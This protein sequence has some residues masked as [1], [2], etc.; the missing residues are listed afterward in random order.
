MRLPRPSALLRPRWPI[1]LLALSIGLT[2][3]GVLEVLRATRSQARVARRVQQDYSRFASWSYRQHLGDAMDDALGDVL[4][5][6]NHG[7]NLH[8]SPR[9]PHARE[10]AHYL[11]YDP[12]CACHRADG[13][14]PAIFFGFTLGSDT[15]GLGINTHA[16]PAEGWEIDRPLPVGA[17]ARLTG[18][19]PDEARWLVDTLT[20][21]VRRGRGNGAFTFVV[22][23]RGDSARFLAYTLMP[24][25]WGD[26]VVYGA[27]YARDALVQGL[28]QVLYERPLLPAALTH[29]RA[30]GD[31]LQVQVSDARGRPLFEPR[32]LE[33]WD[34]DLAAT[35]TMT[36]SLGG[37]VI[38][39]QVRAA[40]ADALVIGGL[41]RSRMPFLLALLGIAGALSVVA[42]AQIRRDVELARLRADFVSSVSH[43]LRT[44][45]A[46][47]RLYLETL[48]LGRFRT[49]EQRAQSIAHVE[50][51]TMRLSHLVERVLRH[52]SSGRADDG[53]RVAVDPVAEARE[54]VEE[55]QPLAQARH[56]SV[57]AA[58]APVPPLALSPD[59]LRHVLLNLLD[60]A[61]KYGPAGQTVR[62]QVAPDGD[63][64]RISVSDE[65]PGV[66]PDE[67]ERVW[68]PFQRGRRT[69]PVA[70]SG[71][72]L[73][74]VR[75]IAARHGGRS[76]VEERPGG[77]ATFVVTLPAARVEAAVPEP[78]AVA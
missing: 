42:I 17:A 23:Q 28:A 54:V 45:L 78:A 58:L 2:A 10:L 75:D 43:D 39:A 61:V 20:A 64:V 19:P 26:T 13:P 46:Q 70:G 21:Q 14:N 7:E 49:E 73:A 5:A 11:E 65:G 34:P 22:G 36:T 30:V 4:G 15:L 33:P 55:F 63:D 16:R 12:R 48:R 35:D 66:P 57:T 24:T 47:M 27:E 71:I 72:G 51:E 67:R 41:P 77:G 44:P 3:V 62:V 40:A 53:A 29:G 69:G 1:V 52:S 37:M 31:L 60:N 74:I 59:A 32:H 18:Y 50:R 8:T 6:V 25:T 9:I 76:W 38:R 68:A 56:A